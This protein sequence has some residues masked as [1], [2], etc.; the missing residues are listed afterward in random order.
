LICAGPAIAADRFDGGPALP[1]D[2][3]VHQ[4]A[5]LPE[6][7]S[8]HD[9]ARYREIFALQRDGKWAAAKEA[10]ARLDDPLLLGHVLAQRYLHRGYRTQY[11]E[12]ASWLAR[13]ADHPEA[14]AIHAL[15]QNRRPSGAI[16]PTEPQGEPLLARGISEDPADLRPPARG[17][18]TQRAAQQK[19]VIRRLARTD[20]AIAEHVLHRA[21]GE[22]IFDEADSDE[23]RADVAEGYL[24]AGENQRALRLAAAMRN[25]AW[26]PLAHWQ[27][28]LATWR[29]GRLEEA[30]NHF[31]T[32]AGLSGLSRWNASA[33]AFWT[34]RVAERAK[35]PAVARRW[36]DA[37]AAQPRT[38]YGLLARKKLGI[39][40][41]F[42]LEPAIFTDIDLR[43]VIGIPPA[44][45][46]L[47][48]LQIGD[49]MGAE[50]ELR[51]LAN[52]APFTLYPALAALAD[53]GNMP[54]LSVQMASLLSEIDGRRHET[55]LYPVPRWEPAGGFAVDRALLF[56]LMR[57]E[58]QFRT[59]AE[60]QAG[61]VGLMQLMPATALDMAERLGLAIGG[62]AGP[63]LTEPRLNVTLGQAFVAR[64]LE[65]EQ[66]RG[67]LILFAAAYNSGPTN[68][69]RWSS[70]PEYGADPL[71]FLESLPSRETRIF[72]E[73][74][75]TNYWVYRLRLGQ[76]SPDLEMLARGTW[77]VYVAQDKSSYEL[78]SD[79]SSR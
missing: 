68:L 34:A 16:A 12:L 52:G 76:P 33:A 8:A 11:G 2:Q 42:E 38:F 72:I 18:T 7:L 63:D 1:V 24:F 22:R 55:A 10:I 45:R 77:P 20:P 57:Q 36:L 64:L 50:N 46:A 61:A 53:R 51:V 79:A 43:A 49:T 15:A 74:V 70:R 60:S 21:E 56:A 47:A 37:A 58:S 30:R 31:E 59:T 66:I 9:A 26:Q 78:V 67:N 14:A 19:Q 40:T 73:R 62:R 32:L 28:G 25:P 3:T 17:G 23:A 4:D 69:M 65:H 48:L 39:A 35:R 75:M 27:A 41:K 44:R 54:T 71:L 29:L 6:V 5:G 13:Y